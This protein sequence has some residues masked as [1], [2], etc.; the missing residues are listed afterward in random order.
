[1]QARRWLL[2]AILFLS[3]GCGGGDNVGDDD[4]SDSVGGITGVPALRVFVDDSDH[5]GPGDR[6]FA[7]NVI[8]T[9]S[10]GQVSFSLDDAIDDC[11]LDFSAAVRVYPA[12]DVLVEFQDGV[13]TCQ[14]SGEQ[15]G[16]EYRVGDDLTITS[17]GTLFR[18]SVRGPTV[19]IKVYEGAVTVS[20]SRTTAPVRVEAAFEVTVVDGDLP[21]EASPSPITLEEF[22]DFERKVFADLIEGLG[23]HVGG[24]ATATTGVATAGVATATATTVTATATATPTPT[25]T[26]TPTATPPPD[27]PAIELVSCGDNGLGLSWDYVDGVSEYWVFRAVDG[28]EVAEAVPYETVTSSSGDPDGDGTGEW[29]DDDVDL[30]L[31]HCYFMTAVAESSQQS[32]PSNEVCAIPEPARPPAPTD[33]TVGYDDSVEWTYDTDDQ[34]AWEITGFE[35]W[36][37]QR[38]TDNQFGFFDVI[39]TVSSG[40]LRSW[41]HTGASGHWCYQI[42]AVS[43]KYGKSSL[44]DSGC[45]PAPVE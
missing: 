6:L 19:R 15:V 7:G 10:T 37:A 11:T 13:T 26:P 42:V 35:I 43:A 20:S 3:I 23:G 9:D 33:V 22:N 25:I 30:Q 38:I 34:E 4:D 31:S 29:C 45:T 44:S 21:P 32:M 16:R 12:E 40:K 27:P 24:T 8:R 39:D 36:G 17:D 41:T 1:M 2:L 14:T 18:V 5:P 28:E